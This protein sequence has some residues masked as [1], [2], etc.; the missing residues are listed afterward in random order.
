[1]EQIIKDNLLNIILCLLV[2]AFG[3]FL[4]KKQNKLADV[5]GSFQLRAYTPTIWTSLGILGTFVSILVSLYMFVKDTSNNINLLIYNIAPAFTTSIIGI[6]GSIITSLNNK[7]HLAIVEKKETKTLVHLNEQIAPNN[8]YSPEIILL[9][10]LKDI[11]DGRKQS[12]K[13]N[14][15]LILK[16]ESI[17]KSSNDTKDELKKSLEGEANTTRE[18]LSGALK[19]QKEDFEK[20]VEALKNAFERT[21]GEQNQILENKLNALDTTLGTKIEAYNTTSQN[22]ITQLINIT[23]D[24]LADESKKRNEDLQKYINQTSGMIEE[25]INGQSILYESINNDLGTI[26]ADIRKLFEE[27]IRLSIEKFAEEQ[28]LISKQTIEEWNTMLVADTNKSFDRH[29]EEMRNH[30]SDFKEKVRSTYQLFEKALNNISIIVADKLKELYDQQTGLVGDTIENNRGQLSNALS[31]NLT[32]INT[33]LEAN[34]NSIKSIAD[35]IKTDNSSIKDILTASQRKLQDNI[36][37]IHAKAESEI[38]EI[39]RKIIAIEESLQ[40]K[41]DSVKDNV[42]KSTT[43]FERKLNEVRDEALKQD[44]KTLQELNKRVQDAFPIEALQTAGI[45]LSTG[46]DETIN[47][48]SSNT[49]TISQDLR[50]ITTSISES[51]SKYAKTIQDY[52]DKLG[53]VESTLNTLKQHITSIKV[54]EQ[55]LL[56]IDESVK[57]VEKMRDNVQDEDI[58]INKTKKDKRSK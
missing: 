53:Y 6:I 5:T 19:E 22:L 33:I 21:L 43:E 7:R 54:L 46:I 30:L 16:L 8:D 40:E 14:D 57:R 36:V 1:M 25:F 12:K 3:Y 50:N 13:E 49:K 23:T 10:I 15:D 55:V 20:N 4:T 34:R 56:D 48:F 52:D 11:K 38:S 18:A 26:V 27:D 44:V 39:Q 31:E 42:V 29:A 32:S 17:N 37:D 58:T 28:H 47:R 24:K 2:L 51:S 45:K 41:L 35:E 9:E